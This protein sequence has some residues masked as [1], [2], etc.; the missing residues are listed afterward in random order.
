[1]L[2]SLNSPALETTED[3]SYEFITT[4][5]QRA[6]MTT[7]VRYIYDCLFDKPSSY[8]LKRHGKHKDR[9]MVFHKGLKIFEGTYKGCQVFVIKRD[10]ALSPSLYA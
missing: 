1:M 5:R 7:T 9:Y 3:S 4:N 10:V 6:M 8:Q 2:L